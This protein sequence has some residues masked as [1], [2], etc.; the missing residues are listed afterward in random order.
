MHFL[1]RRTDVEW[2]LAGVDLLV[3][4]SDLEGMP[5]VAI[6]AAMAGCPVVSIPVGGIDE[7]VEDGVT[8][9]V[10]ADADPGRMAEAV[11]ALL[12][13]A[14]RRHAM[15]TAARAGSERFSAAT[16]ARAYA[17]ALVALVRGS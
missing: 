17:D 9:L 11:A 14:D 6:E 3:L 2:I 13:D 5:G 4:T 12:A 7:V 15:G 8:G 1:G 16:T 10:L